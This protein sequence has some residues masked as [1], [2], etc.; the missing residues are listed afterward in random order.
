MNSRGH[1]L[2]ARAHRRRGM[3]LLEIICV[4]MVVGFTLGLV[5][6]VFVTQLDVTRR[7]TASAGRAAAANSLMLR[8]RSDLLAAATISVSNRPADAEDATT[9]VAIN[10]L[11]GKTSCSFHRIDRRVEDAER[12]PAIDQVIVR[13]DAD[14]EE[15]RWTLQAQTIDV[16][17]SPAAPSRILLLKFK[18]NGRSSPGFNRRENLEMS[19]LTG[20]EP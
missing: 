10:G 16:E 4:V 14:G 2:Q 3:T 13:T 15:H 8:L 6:E 7:L 20:G 12:D 5:T 9:T 11:A 17:A 19:L 1:K 18:Q